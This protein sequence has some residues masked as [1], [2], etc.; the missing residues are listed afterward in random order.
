MDNTKREKLIE[1]IQKLLRLS[2][3]PNEHEAA[4]AAEMAQELLA[5]YN[6]TMDDVKDNYNQDF[7]VDSDE[8]TESRPWRRSL[9][10]MVAKLYFSQ[11]FFTYRKTRT[12][13]RKCGYIRD[14][15]HNFVGAPHNVAVA[16]MMFVYL[17]SVVQ[18]LAMAGATKVPVKQRGSYQ[19][20]FKHAC[21]WRLCA[22]IQ[23]R[24]DDA[25]AGKVKAS[26]G[27]NLPALADLYKQTQEEIDGFLKSKGTQLEVPNFRGK[28]N[29]PQGISEGIDAADTVAL[30]PAIKDAKVSGYL[31]TSD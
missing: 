9:G 25:K 31:L 19:T 27:S 23:K 8:V 21:G 1:K 6:L 16:K 10:S 5:Q 28:L 4:L 2:T 13:Q 26:D 24:I 30:D 12:D 18:N 14:D 29:N 15:I 3:S 22:R 7:V 17:C 20:S 11:Y